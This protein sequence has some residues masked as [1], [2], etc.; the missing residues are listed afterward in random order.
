MER[1]SYPSQEKLMR[2]SHA[3]LPSVFAGGSGTPSASEGIKQYLGTKSRAAWGL[4]Y[5]MDLVKEMGHLRDL[6]L[7]VTRSK[8]SLDPSMTKALFAETPLRFVLIFI[9]HAIGRKRR[10]IPVQPMKPL[11]FFGKNRTMRQIRIKKP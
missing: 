3:F 9:K 4:A 10:A 5:W 2:A 8:A 7:L 1:F 6:S 11:C